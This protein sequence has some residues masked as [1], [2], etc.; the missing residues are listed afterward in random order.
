MP[1]VIITAI[2]W[3]GW[4]YFPLIIVPMLLLSG[5]YNTLAS[6]SDISQVILIVKQSSNVRIGFGKSINIILSPNSGE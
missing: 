3:I 4:F 6:M 1:L 2:W 5:I